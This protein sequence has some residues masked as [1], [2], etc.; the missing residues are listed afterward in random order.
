MATSG[1]S[2]PLLKAKL[3][4]QELTLKKKF[5]ADNFENL[6]RELER[7]KSV[8]TNN[9]LEGVRLA[10]ANALPATIQTAAEAAAS[11]LESAPSK[12]KALKRG[13]F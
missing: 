13:K 8:A 10:T 6:E 9:F 12:P 2:G 11:A 1:Y 4:E 3:R 5:K 7:M